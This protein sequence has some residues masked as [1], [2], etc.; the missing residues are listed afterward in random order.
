MF[1]DFVYNPIY[2]FI[3][4]LYIYNIYVCVFLYLYSKFCLFFFRTHRL[5]AH[6]SPLPC[7][8]ANKTP[9]ILKASTVGDLVISVVHVQILTAWHSSKHIA[10]SMIWHTVL[11]D[12]FCPKIVVKKHILL[13]RTHRI[14]CS[15]FFTSMFVCN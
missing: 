8:C 11:I 10:K 7:L 6:H 4:C 9:A 1:I 13:F 15:S 3:I 2:V 14:V 12:R 5:F